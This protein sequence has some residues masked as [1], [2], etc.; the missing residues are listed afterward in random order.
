MLHRNFRGLRKL[1]VYSGCLFSPVIGERL[2]SS[3][4]WFELAKMVAVF[5]SQLHE[6]LFRR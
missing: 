2:L 1:F 6:M 5:V 4:T 3:R